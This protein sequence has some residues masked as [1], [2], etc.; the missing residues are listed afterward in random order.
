ML[1][2]PTQVAAAIVAEVGAGGLHFMV[3]SDIVAV[4]NALLLPLSHFILVQAVTPSS[5]DTTLYL[6]LG[7]GLG[8]GLIAVISFSTVMVV[9]TYYY[10]R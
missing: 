7:L 6:G 5:Q 1:L 9:V 10:R 2:Y 3:D 4:Q 8:L